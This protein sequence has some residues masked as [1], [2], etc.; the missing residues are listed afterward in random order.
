MTGANTTQLAPY[1]PVGTNMHN[2]AI[3]NNL[4]INESG[5]EESQVNSSVTHNSSV[6][7]SNVGS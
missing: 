4:P 1:T 5:V 6:I 7:K 3:G 2:V